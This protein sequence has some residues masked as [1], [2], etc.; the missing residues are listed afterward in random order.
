MYWNDYIGTTNYPSTADK[1]ALDADFALQDYTE[2]RI[3]WSKIDQ[4]Y[5][6]N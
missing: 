4:I 6:T 1:T 5:G 2:G 3:M